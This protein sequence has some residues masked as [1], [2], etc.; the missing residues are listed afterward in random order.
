M[1]YLTPLFFRSLWTA[2]TS[3]ETDG[4]GVPIGMIQKSG[5]C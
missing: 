1:L 4:V 5:S 2:A 3:L